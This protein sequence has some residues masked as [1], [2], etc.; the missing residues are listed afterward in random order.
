[1]RLGM[2]SVRLNAELGRRQGR[3]PAAGWAGVALLARWYNA[4]AL[5]RSI[6]PFALLRRGR[7]MRWRSRAVRICTSGCR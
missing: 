1:M 6:T 3:D 2:S 4:A 7:E 5:A